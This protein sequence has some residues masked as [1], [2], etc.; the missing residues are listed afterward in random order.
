MGLVLVVDDERGVR[1]GLVR[2]LKSAGHEAIACEGLTEARAALARESAIDC[3]L[4]D[5]RL[6]DGDGIQ[7]LREVK[8]SLAP[9]CAVVM[10]TAFGDSERTIEA[11]KLGA[12]DY[13]TKPFDLDGLLDTVARAVRQ[14]SLER[15][16]TAVISAG[17]AVDTSSANRSLIG[18]SAPMLAVWK[19]IGRAASTDA[20]VLVTGETGTG[21]ELVARAIHEHSSRARAPFVAVN[22]AA[23]APTLLEAELFGHEKG[24]F[25]G[26]TS[27]KAGRLELAGEGTL[28][29]D[30]IGDLDLSLQTRLLR[31]LN[32]RRFER[33]GGGNESL[34][35]SARIIAATHKP[36]RPTEPNATLREDLY[37]RLAVIEIAL[38]PLRE[39][40]SDIPLLVANALSRSTARAVSEEAMAALLA[41]GWPGNVRELTHVIDRAAAMCGGEV[42]DLP[43]LPATVR[44]AKSTVRDDRPRTS[45]PGPASDRTPFDDMPLRDALAALEKRLIVRALERAQG[46]RAEAARILGIARPQLYSKM[47]EHGLR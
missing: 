16:E 23:L 1:E 5:V 40:R 41:Y 4:L 17:P 24:S 43:D 47:E 42:I 25:T 13:V 14:R 15:G 19:A 26:A 3:V 7:F 20:P 38:P 34:T 45:D 18:S 29:L 44:E 35:F 6:K 12:F 39:R 8:Q 46:N 37:Y 10:A 30:E 11:M 9:D 22:L 32:D 2:A 36:V 27:R 33:V 31:V 28:F 21:K